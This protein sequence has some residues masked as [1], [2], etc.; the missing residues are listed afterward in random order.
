M[1]FQ[2]IS[3]TCVLK[4]A[5]IIDQQLVQHD[6]EIHNNVWLCLKSRGRNLLQGDY[7]GDPR[8]TGSYEAS[9]SAS[10]VGVRGIA[11]GISRASL[12]ASPWV[13]VA[14]AWQDILT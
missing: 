3:K 14:C 12:A 9:E 10:P 8:S 11:R 5:L 1:E 13:L 7:L 4:D 6:T 2:C